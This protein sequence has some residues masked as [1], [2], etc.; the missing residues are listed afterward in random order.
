MIDKIELKHREQDDEVF[1]VLKHK[2]V[3]LKKRDIARRTYVDLI[4]KEAE[5]AALK[6]E[7]LETKEAIYKRVILTLVTHYPKHAIASQQVQVMHSFFYFRGDLYCA[8][9]DPPFTLQDYLDSWNKDMQ[10]TRH[11]VL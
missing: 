6:A 9:E 4:V 2:D 5:E 3:G 11:K 7:K 8:V 1:F 10:Q